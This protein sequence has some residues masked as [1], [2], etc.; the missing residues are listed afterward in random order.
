MG[1]FNNIYSQ[2]YSS[3]SNPELFSDDELESYLIENNDED[4]IKELYLGVD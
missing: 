4:E 1:Y 2:D 3:R